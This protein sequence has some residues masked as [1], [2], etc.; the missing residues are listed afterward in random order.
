MIVRTDSGREIEA[1]AVGAQ[2][3]PPPADSGNFPVRLR[4]VPPWA[5]MT[6]ISFLGAQDLGSAVAT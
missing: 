6:M 2:V 4:G 1:F 3:M 5:E